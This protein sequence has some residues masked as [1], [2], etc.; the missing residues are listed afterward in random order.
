MNDRRDHR[1][2]MERVLSAALAAAAVLS[3]G[4]AVMASG[5]HG[6][7]SHAA[8]ASGDAD[9]N[10]SGLALGEYRIR[11]YYP[12]QA[13]KS[14]VRFV[15]HATAQEGHYAE[16][17]RIIHS[18]RHKLRDQVITATR[19][20]PLAEYN[21]AELKSFRRRVLLRLRRTLPELMLDD[22]YVSDF[23]LKVQSL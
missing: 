2:L 12:V 11:S 23:Q 15:L 4:G 10:S 7:S 1:C 19:L 20:V 21:E 14:V 9:A 6:D 3:F 22:I 17:K 13:Q 8:E 5:G 18:R 16:A